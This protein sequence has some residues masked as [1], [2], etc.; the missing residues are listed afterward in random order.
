MNRFHPKRR[1]SVK[2]SAR[3][4]MQLGVLAALTLVLAV[5]GAAKAGSDRHVAS[6]ARVSVPVGAGN[7]CFP[8][9]DYA[10]AGCDKAWAAFQAAKAAVR[11]T[12]TFVAKPNPA[13]SCAPLH[14][15]KSGRC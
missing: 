4:L 10:S 12:S 7:P 6:T 3:T 8:L 5:A 13:S 14:D 9:H 11:P 15:Y 2:L 1:I